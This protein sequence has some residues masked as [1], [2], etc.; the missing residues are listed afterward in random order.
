MAFSLKWKLS[1]RVAE[2]GCA[3]EAG[4]C[5]N[6][7]EP[8][9]R[10]KGRELLDQLGDCRLLERQKNCGNNKKKL[11]SRCKWTRISFVTIREERDVLSGKR[12]DTLRSAENWQSLLNNSAGRLQTTT[13][14][15]TWGN[16]CVQHMVKTVR[17]LHFVC[18]VILSL[19]LLKQSCDIEW[20]TVLRVVLY[21]YENWSLT[22]MEKHR[23]RV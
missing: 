12:N 9:D 17:V 10:T 2:S 3:L 22:L 21:G 14:R 23:L 16:D 8:C 15:G 13:V 11:D 7:N 1:T 4:F 20:T 5:E 19:S 6:R 18:N